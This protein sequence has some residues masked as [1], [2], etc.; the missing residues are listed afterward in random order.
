MYVHVRVLWCI[1]LHHPVNVRK[2][3][4]SEIQMRRSMVLETEVWRE[5]DQSM[6]VEEGL[7]VLQG[8][9]IRVS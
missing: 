1:Y 5:E 4:A 6:D 3:Q 8:R 9:A 7:S 2:V